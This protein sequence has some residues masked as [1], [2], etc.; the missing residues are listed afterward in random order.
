M[1]RPEIVNR[2][3]FEID[4]LHCH[5][6]LLKVPR[7]YYQKILNASGSFALTAHPPESDVHPRD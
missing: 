3:S 1:E 4:L 7:T 5:T 2:H 6:D